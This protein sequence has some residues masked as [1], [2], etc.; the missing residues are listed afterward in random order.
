[1][2]SKDGTVVQTSKWGRNIGQSSDDPLKIQ[3]SNNPAIALVTV[4]LTKMNYLMWSRSVR[5]ALTAKNKLGFIS[6]MMQEPAGEPE[7]SAWRRA[8]EMVSSW[9]INS[10]SK[11]NAK[12]FVYSTSVR[13]LWTNLEERFGGSNGPQIY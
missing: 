3:T 5:R 2:A 4:L 10:I 6:G 9:I 8:D 7:K 11:E 1:M 13:G 12:T